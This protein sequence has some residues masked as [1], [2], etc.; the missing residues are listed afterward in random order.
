MGGVSRFLALLLDV[1]FDHFEWERH[2][3]AVHEKW[4]SHVEKGE[5]QWQGAQPSKH[6]VEKLKD[7]AAEATRENMAYLQ[8]AVGKPIVAALKALQSV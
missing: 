3:F 1:F 4:T 8:Q 5:K 7:R 2:V 6:F